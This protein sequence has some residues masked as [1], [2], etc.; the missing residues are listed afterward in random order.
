[1]LVAGRGTETNGIPITISSS[2]SSPRT[3]TVVQMVTVGVIEATGLRLPRNLPR[4]NEMPG[5]HRL[6]TMPAVPRV[7]KMVEILV[8]GKGSQGLLPTMPLA[9]VAAVA[10]VA[11]TRRLAR[12]MSER[13][14]MEVVA[15]PVIEEEIEAATA[16]PIHTSAEAVQEGG[17]LN[18]LPEAV[19]AAA[20]AG[21]EAGTE[22]AGAVIIEE[23]A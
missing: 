9:A 11:I 13:E 5:P 23:K 2:S 17:G 4:I 7:M 20:E 15:A 6:I 10:A 12:G 22:E 14:T 21:E 16:M 18:L 3:G 19:A 1:M 8:R